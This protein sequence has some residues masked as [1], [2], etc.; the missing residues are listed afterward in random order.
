MDFAEAMRVAREAGA[1]LPMHAFGGTL[2]R[3]YWVGDGLIDELEVFVPCPYGAETELAKRL[4]PGAEAD[5]QRY[6]QILVAH[7]SGL[8]LRYLLCALPFEETMLTR[9]IEHDGVRI[10]SAEDWLLLALFRFRP[11]VE[12]EVRALLAA[13]RGYLQWPYID[14][15]LPQLAE[16]KEDPRPLA[17]LQSIRERNAAL[18]NGDN[19]LR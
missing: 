8:R 15:W 13:R 10:I 11:G 9:A 14:H 3:R 6:R 19:G 12:S 2:A 1:S 4:A 18:A 7:P 5:A 17:L 16:L